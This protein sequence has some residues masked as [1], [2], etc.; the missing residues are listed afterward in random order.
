MKKL[1]LFMAMILVLGVQP[2][3]AEKLELFEKLDTNKDGKVS[4]Q[5]FSQIKAERAKRAERAFT[6]FD[7]NEDGYLDQ[8]EWKVAKA[9]FQEWAKNRGR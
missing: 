7:S 6:R 1:I 4:S 3:F 2:S 9:K 8:N 5:E